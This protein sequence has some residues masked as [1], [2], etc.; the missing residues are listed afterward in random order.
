MWIS[1]YVCLFIIY[2]FMGWVYET[3]FCT[4][5]DGKWENR[6]FLYG[7]VCPIYGTG[8]IAISVIMKLT[9]ES[10]IELI[11]WQIF[12][13][14]VVGSAVL[15]YVTSWALEKL[16]HAIWWDYSNLPL[17]LHGRISLFTSLGFGLGGLLIVY[18]IAPY[19]V[20]CVEFIPPL[21]MELLALCFVFL[22]AV[23]LTLTVTALH[24]FDRMVVRMEDRF[25]HR[26][27]TIVDTTVQQSA[28]IKERIVDN[29]NLINERNERLNVLS[30]FM[31]GTVRRVYSFRDKNEKQETVKNDLLLK[32]QEFTKYE[33]IKKIR[34]L[35]KV[36]RGLTCP[37]APT[38]PSQAAGSGTIAK[39]HL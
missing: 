39:K 17:N 25:N 4:I 32:I 8:A 10:Q 18:I 12:L 22:F 14:S 1:R 35:T 13:I 29:A 26:M 23:D 30:S 36:L 15:E 27:E 11:W 34:N 28:L 37:T 9:L 5:K 38:L 7:P 24:H 33:K 3:I 2:S 6:G 16:F 31:K 21:I 19:T 20:N